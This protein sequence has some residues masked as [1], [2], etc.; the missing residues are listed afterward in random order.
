MHMWFEQ[1][2][3]SHGSL[4]SRATHWLLRRL[5][6]RSQDWRW[7]RVS[8]AYWE[9]SPFREKTSWPRLFV[10]QAWLLQ[11]KKRKA[12]VREAAHFMQI[13]RWMQHR[14]ALMRV[15]CIFFFKQALSHAMACLASTVVKVH[16]FSTLTLASLASNTGMHG[17]EKWHASMEVPSGWHVTHRIGAT[18]S[19]DH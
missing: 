12:D 6:P 10:A 7:C 2:E 3:F 5:G 8:G 17:H 18:A 13:D 11:E 19:D 9:L 14:R 15:T 16:A 1:Q 4:T